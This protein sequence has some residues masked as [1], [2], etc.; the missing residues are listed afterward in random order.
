MK[1]DRIKKLFEEKVAK[2][3]TVY[4]WVRTNRSQ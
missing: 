4:G 1:R 2:E 3:A